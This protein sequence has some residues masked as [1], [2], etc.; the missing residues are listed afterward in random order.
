MFLVL[1]IIGYVAGI[2]HKL[3]YSRDMVTILYAVNA[4]MVFIDMLLYFRN[5]RLAAL[6][7]A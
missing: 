2:I 3:I 6:K 7:Q 5:K 4:T 1:I